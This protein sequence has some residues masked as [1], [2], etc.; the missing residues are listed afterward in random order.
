M[1][2]PAELRGSYHRTSWHYINK[3]MFLSDSDRMALEDSLALNLELD[4]PATAGKSMNVIQVIRLT[5]KTLPGDAAS[6]EDNWLGGKRL[7]QS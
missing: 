6:A 4:P 7:A 1:G 2:F 3:P 5:R